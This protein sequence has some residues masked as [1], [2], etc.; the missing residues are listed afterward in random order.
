MCFILNGSIVAE[1]SDTVLFEGYQYFPSDIV[2]KE[3]FH[4][5]LS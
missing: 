4:E 5:E 2:N 3:L 1:S